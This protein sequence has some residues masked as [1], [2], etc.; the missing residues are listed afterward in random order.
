MGLPIPFPSDSLIEK[1]TYRGLL[2][3]LWI[4][5]S[6]DY[7]VFEDSFQGD[8]LHTLY[9]AAKTDSGT[10]VFTADNANNFLEIKSGGANGNYAGQGLGLTLTGDR[11]VLLEGIIRTPATITDMKWEFGLS[12]THSAD[13]GAVNQ[14]AT[15]TT[16]N[17]VDTAVFVYDT[18]DDANIAFVTAK[19]GGVVEVQ[20]IQALLVSTTYRLAIR[21]EGDNVTAYIDGREVA[22]SGGGVGIEGGNKLT[23]WVF[24]QARSGSERI[25][26]LHKWR[27]IQPAY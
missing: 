5:S 11:G 3:N 17:A 22:G 16:V 4:P 27:T 14:K 24:S 13:A 2:R 15:T 10:V 12:D 8:T 26:Q 1:K 21:V 18:T 19:A 23:P 7:T 25:L 6:F 20:D 9:P